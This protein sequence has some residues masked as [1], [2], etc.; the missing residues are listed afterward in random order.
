MEQSDAQMKKYYRERA[1]IYDRVYSYPERQEDLRFLENYIAEQFKGRD[2]LEVAAGTGYWTQF[3]LQKSASLLATDATIEALEQIKLRPCCENISTKVI[4]AYSI[5]HL[6]RYFN[7]VFAGLWL[8]HVPKQRL[9]EFIGK[10]SEVTS[11]EAIVL[12][13]DNS[14]AQCDRLPIAYTDDEGNTYQDRVLEDGST[15]KVLKNFPS[16]AG[17]S[18]VTEDFGQNLKYMEL[19]NFWLF[20]YQTV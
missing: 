3:I 19:E 6:G 20:Q 11:P 10:I 1:P 15:H 7:A 2:V 14:K 9:K 4:D 16:E 13:I 5:N 8:S 12:F 18:E 17:L